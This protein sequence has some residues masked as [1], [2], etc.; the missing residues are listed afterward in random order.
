MSSM[1][2]RA[3]SPAEGRAGA[4]KPP[5]P[6]HGQ[7]IGRLARLDSTLTELLR[8]I[9]DEARL[10]DASLED[11]HKLVQDIRDVVKQKI[12]GRNGPLDPVAYQ[13]NYDAFERARNTEDDMHEVYADDLERYERRRTMDLSLAESDPDRLT[14]VN[15]RR[16]Y[17]L[18]L[19]GVQTEVSGILNYLRNRP[20]RP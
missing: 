2:E 9:E 16:E 15:R 6:P 4:P 18:A 7:L 1:E 13:D 8:P 14:L 20:S 12:F 10:M 17:I 19:K 5:R 3:G 11:A